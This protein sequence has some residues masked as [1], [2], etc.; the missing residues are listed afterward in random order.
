MDR[1]KILVVDDDELVRRQ[2]NGILSEKYEVIMAQSGAVAIELYEKMHPDMILSDL[3]MPEMNGFEMMEA[4]REKHD[5]IIPVMFMTALSSDE[6]EEKSLTTGAVDYIRKPFKADVLLKRIDN[7]IANLDRISGLRKAAENDPMTGL[8][9]KTTSTRR[10]D[11][12]AHSGQGILMMIDLDSFKLVND[13][14][15]HEKG[16]QIL[17]KFAELLKSIMRSTDIIGR[18]GGD[19]FVAFCQNTKDE[20]MLQE[21]TEFLNRKL[22]KLARECLAEDMNIPLGCSIGAV[23]CPDEG[24]DFFT[25]Y[26]K[27]DQALYNVKSNGKHGYSFFKQDNT[28]KTETK[29]DSFSELRM[30]LGERE[31]QRGA[32]VLPIDFF[33]VIYRFF[34]RLHRNYA[35]DIQ[36]GIFTLKKEDGAVYEY[37]EKFLEVAASCLRASDVIAKYG[38]NQIIV[39][40]L[41]NIPDEYH[42]PIERVLDRW[43]ELPESKE[44]TLEYNSQN[45]M[46]E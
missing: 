7:I 42:I 41:K 30:I 20:R 39:L 6:S 18:V 21:R 10:I 15:G 22:T 2:I 1:K 31:G 46:K 40:L 36:F 45:F 35:Y 38:D 14:Y 34:V 33:K 32:Y 12:V 19:E 17:I 3:I 4:L 8:L 44:V 23:I 27:A 37:V 24:N 28:V 9:N 26:K 43:N 13:I 25:L 16:D 29:H 5:V 11:E